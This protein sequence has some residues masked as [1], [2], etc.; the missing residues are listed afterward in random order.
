MLNFDFLVKGLGI[1]SPT[2]FVYD[3]TTKMFLVLYSINGPNFIAQLPLLFEILGNMCIKIVCYPGCD[4]MDFEANLI[5]LIEPFF[6]H[7]Q[8]VMAKT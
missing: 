3:F 5:F 7:D 4:V 6:L 2:Y 8:K 1:I